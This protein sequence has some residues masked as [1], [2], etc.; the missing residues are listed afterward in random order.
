MI[1]RYNKLVRD[2]IP[3]IISKQGGFPLTEQL[4]GESYAEALHSKLAEEVAEYFESRSIEELAD[5]VEVIYALVK[6]RGLSIKD[7]ESARL[8]KY[9]DAGGFENGIFLVEVRRGLD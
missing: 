8:K 9:D 2:K 5:I 1:D 7:L 6:Q 3:Q 4:I